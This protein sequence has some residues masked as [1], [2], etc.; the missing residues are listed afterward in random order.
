MPKDNNEWELTIMDAILSRQQNIEEIL[1]FNNQSA[2]YG[3]TM[4]TQQAIALTESCKDSLKRNRRIELNG[5]I[6]IRLISS[7]CDSP[8][9]SQQDYEETLHELID[10]FY[11]FKNDT[12]DMI[13]DNELIEFMK[14][15]FNSNCCGSCEMLAEELMRLSQHIHEGKTFCCYNC[16]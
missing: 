3:L 16:K 13:T 4:T 6:I 12:W 14:E 8:Y 10:L 7:F 11:D 2:Q 15:A 1:A 5:N 9:I